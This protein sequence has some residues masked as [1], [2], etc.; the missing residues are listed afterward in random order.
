MPYHRFLA[1][2][3]ARN[4]ALR[5]LNEARVSLFQRAEQRAGKKPGSVNE[6][7]H[8]L[9]FGPKRARAVFGEHAPWRYALHVADASTQGR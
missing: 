8:L 6:A 9:G 7:L 1:S 2:E 4:S 5:N 3:A